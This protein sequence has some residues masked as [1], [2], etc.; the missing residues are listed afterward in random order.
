ME[1]MKIKLHTTFVFSIRVDLISKA[2]AQIYNFIVLCMFLNLPNVT[3]LTLRI[4]VFCIF[5]AIK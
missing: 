2:A 3:Y 1:Q 4:I 5:K